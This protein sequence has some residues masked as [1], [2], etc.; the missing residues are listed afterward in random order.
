[1]ANSGIPTALVGQ[2]YHAIDGQPAA[3]ATRLDIAFNP[4]LKRRFGMQGYIGTQ[5]GQAGTDINLTFASPTNKAQFN[6]LALAAQQKSGDLGFNYD[7]WEGGIGTGNHWL[8]T[9]CFAG[10][11]RLTNDP[12]SG[13][14]DRTISI[15]G[16][17]P[18]LIA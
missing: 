18:R 4:P 8:V 1:M 15:S 13:D 10:N 2:I 3:E 6:L 16:G 9:N 11:Y 7:W 14:S 17:P 12:E 5:K